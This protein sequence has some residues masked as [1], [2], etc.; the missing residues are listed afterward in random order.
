[1]FAVAAVGGISEEMVP[2]QLVIPDQI[3]DYTY[4]RKQTFFEEDLES[5]THI[6]FTY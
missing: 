6:D 3:V 2:G 1:M 4:S 5:V